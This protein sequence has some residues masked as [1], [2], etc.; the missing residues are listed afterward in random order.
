[1]EPL[2]AIGAVASI[3]QLANAALSLSKILYSLGSAIGSASEDVQILAADLK[4]FSQSLTLLSR[5][6]EDS[7]SWYSDDIYLLTAKIIKDCA[8]LYVKIEKI[9]V[10]LGANGKSNW[11]L[12]VKFVY[13]ESEIK[14]L[15]KR[16]RDMK[17]T[18]ATILMSL[19]VDLQL[20]L[21]NLSSSSSL[22]SGEGRDVPDISLQPETLQTLKDAQKAVESGGFM[23]KYTVETKQVVELSEKEVRVSTT[24]H[25]EVKQHPR[26]TAG[27]LSRSAAS[28]NRT[29]IAQTDIS[30]E[31]PDLVPHQATNA[32][33]MPQSFMMI[34]PDS[35]DMQ[36]VFAVKNVSRTMAK[37]KSSQIRERNATDPVQAAQVIRSPV[38]TDKRSVKSS[39]SV[40]SFK[41]AKSIQEEDVEKARKIQAVQR[42]MHAFRSSLEVLNSLIERRIED[43]R[44]DLYTSATH[45][46]GCLVDGREHI[47]RRNISHFKQYGK[48][49]VYLFE[50][51]HSTEVE[52]FGS[53][54]MQDVGIKLHEYTS[55]Y[56]EL[57]NHC[58]ELL[59]TS[60]ANIER[61]VIDYLDIMANL[62]SKIVHNPRTT[63]GTSF[64]GYTYYNRSSDYKPPPPKPLPPPPTRW[65]YTRILPE[66]QMQ[67][68]AIA[69]M[70]PSFS[71]T[72]PCYSPTSPKFHSASPGFSPAS[73]SYSSA[74]PAIPQFGCA[75]EE[76][77]SLKRESLDGGSIANYYNSPELPPMLP[78][79]TPAESPG[80]SPL[81]Y[82]KN[83]IG[84]GDTN[85]FTIPSG[86]SRDTKIDN[87]P[88]LLLKRGPHPSDYA[89][90][91][92]RRLPPLEAA[93]PHPSITRPQSFHHQPP[94]FPSLQCNSDQTPL[95]DSPHIKTPGQ[96][97]PPNSRDLPPISLPMT[98]RRN[99]RSA[100][101]STPARPIPSLRQD[102]A[103]AGNSDDTLFEMD[104]AKPSTSDTG[105]LMDFDFDSF[106]SEDAD[107]PFDFGEPSTCLPP[108]TGR[109]SAFKEEI[110]E[111]DL[112]LSGASPDTYSL[113]TV[114]PK[115]PTPTNVWWSSFRGNAGQRPDS[116]PEA[117]GVSHGEENEDVDLSVNSVN[118]I[119]LSAANGLSESQFGRK[120][121]REGSTAVPS[122]PLQRP[123]VS[124]PNKK[125]HMKE[126]LEQRN[127]STAKPQ[128]PHLNTHISHD[129]PTTLPDIKLGSEDAAAEDG[130]AQ[131]TQEKR[132][133]DILAKREKLRQLRVAREARDEASADRN[134]LI[135]LVS[136]QKAPAG[137]GPN[138]TASTDSTNNSGHRTVNANHTLQDYQMQLMLLE[139]QNKKRRMMAQ[140][141]RDNTMHLSRGTVTASTDPTSSS[142][143]TL[144]PQNRS[145][146]SSLP[147]RENANVLGSA[148]ELSQSPSVISADRLRLDYQE[149][150]AKTRQNQEQ[151]TN[152]RLLMSKNEETADEAVTILLQLDPSR[153]SKHP[154]RTTEVDK[155]ALQDYQMS[156]MNLTCGNPK[157]RMM[158]RADGKI[159]GIGAAPAQTSD[160]VIQN[161][162]LESCGTCG[163]IA[164]HAKDCAAYRRSKAI[165]TVGI[166]ST[167]AAAPQGPARFDHV[168]HDALQDFDFDSFLHHDESSNAFNFDPVVLSDHS[169]P[170]PS[171]GTSN[172]PPEPEPP[173]TGPSMTVDAGNNDNDDK[174]LFV[175]A[176]QFHRLLKRREARQRLEEQ[177]AS[178]ASRSHNTDNNKPSKESQDTR[179][180]ISDKSTLEKGRS[181]KSDDGAFLAPPTPLDSNP[182]NAEDV[183][184]AWSHPMLTP[185]QTSRLWWQTYISFTAASSRKSP[186]FANLSSALH[187]E[188][189]FSALS[190]ASDEDICKRI[191][192]NVKPLSM[193]GSTLHED[194]PELRDVLFLRGDIVRMLLTV[195]GRLSL[196]TATVGWSC[197]CVFVKIFNKLLNRNSPLCPSSLSIVETSF[198]QLQEIV[199]I[200]ARYAVMENLYQQS[201]T[202]G[203]ST[204]LSLKPE[205]QSSLLS[206]CSSILEWFAASYDIGHTVVDVSN[207]G[208]AGAVASALLEELDEKVVKCGELM[209]VIREKNKGCQ[210]FRVEVDVNDDGGSE[211]EGENTDVEDVSDASW[212]EIGEDDI[213]ANVDGE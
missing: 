167:A 138:R 54:L 174:P 19:Q 122:P 86:V 185:A 134:T 152:D 31:Y 33:V 142:V 180:A 13:K 190:Y 52:R 175:N 101:S 151:H 41:S 72:S 103:R 172:E 212:E 184:L 18:L 26:A 80:S 49:Y 6:L 170:Q 206:L 67:D 37:E 43:K 176:K 135:D 100:T 188:L 71:P 107:T 116:R 30:S 192:D 208:V 114:H 79:T 62:A 70:S 27:F 24:H 47:D 63:L 118:F 36:N 74:S 96:H 14:K 42:V 165:A 117:D 90:R 1:M 147:I 77:T 111:S 46:K 161:D 120:R 211:D 133:N 119:K 207:S 204:T 75:S 194:R 66:P 193:A 158:Y 162:K 150:L 132:Q 69:P 141:E 125:I 57:E 53:L 39:S 94:I 177:I 145:S 173:T 5:L 109:K 56:E 11:K 157:R 124:S 102:A 40:E 50:R 205:Y 154:V 64:T 68:T 29:P 127:S 23:T 186:V 81:R 191:V 201:I 131:T 149:H 16:L 195:D 61:Q 187:S 82:S 189:G 196:E 126:R 97:R 65:Q 164:H 209:G 171:T 105:E 7:K 35:T 178:H 110:M 144:E 198:S 156:L 123:V 89:P 58:F 168:M 181:T 48:D 38:D 60:T 17:G 2:A 121:R 153:K 45:L 10:K 106:L 112:L 88:S 166:A 73:P 199:H 44:W 99:G 22:S 76:L 129:L 4:T 9:L 87:P 160:P 163:G 148:S 83:T 213:K 12:R 182:N 200:I 143:S 113:S 146:E 155:K 34:P 28:E 108:G 197:V 203:T 128:S 8:E 202:S 21:L 32:S 51:K 210:I 92:Y 98:Q 20:S 104:F 95:L 136:A 91:P 3:C 85:T 169:P 137:K 59:A 15:L 115:L 179:V 140:Q 78:Q 159:A 130:S 139:Q 183:E 84:S 25:E 93:G 55:E